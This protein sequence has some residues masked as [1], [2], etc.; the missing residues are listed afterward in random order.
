[1]L[2]CD[3]TPR[4]W[5]PT[6]LPLLAMLAAWLAFMPLSVT[7]SFSASRPSA[8]SRA[9]SSSASCSCRSKSTSRPSHGW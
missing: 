2:S 6:L 9:L 7:S 4:R 8:S 1:M 3:R 5:V